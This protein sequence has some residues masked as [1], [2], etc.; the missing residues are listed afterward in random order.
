MRR[1][2]A[3]V[4]PLLVAAAIAAAVFLLSKPPEASPGA[5]F[6]VV[7]AF[8]DEDAVSM[9]EAMGRGSYS[10]GMILSLMSGGYFNETTFLLSTPDG[11]SQFSGNTS[12]LLLKG[13]GWG[14]RELRIL[15]FP[16]NRTVVIEA[17]NQ[18]AM[19]VAIDRLLLAVAGDRAIDLSPTRRYLV[20]FAGGKKS[21]P[22]L[23][24][25]DRDAVVSLVPV[26]GG[27]EQIRE[28][29]LDGVLRW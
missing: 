23:S 12:F 16:E 13:P 28:I 3:V 19:V 18:S 21:V 7:M 6:R 20:V 17:P 11:L 25:L 4:L 5:P 27:E 22:W 8:S 9:P 10:I 2:A 1:V 15:S 26:I 29:L 24:G 14:A